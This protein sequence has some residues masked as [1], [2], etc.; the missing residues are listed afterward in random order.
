MRASPATAR[1]LVIGTLLAILSAGCL[2]AFTL[3]AGSTDYPSVGRVRAAEPP[4]VAA[5]V[6]LSARPDQ[7]EGPSPRIVPDEAS[8]PSEPIVLGIRIPKNGPRDEDRDRDRKPP[9]KTP[10]K[11]PPKR[12]D[13]DAGGEDPS[14]PRVAKPITDPETDVHVPRGH[15]YGHDKKARS[16]GP[17]A[18]SSASSAPRN[19]PPAHATAN[20]HDD[21]PSD[22]PAPPP[23]T[24]NG[25][26]SGPPAQPATSGQDEGSGP[27]PHTSANGNAKKAKKS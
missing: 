17:P 20:G 8:D 2:I 15:A 10:K 21:D 16:V 7:D 1:S 18:S 14:P 4:D 6:T 26:P 23:A 13:R 12:D 3:V 11:D 25:N 5:P 24:G 22:A 9:S 27:P 19:G